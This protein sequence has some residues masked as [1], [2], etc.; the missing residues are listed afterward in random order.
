MSNLEARWAEKT[1]WAVFKRKS[2][3]RTQVSLVRLG[4]IQAYEMRIPGPRGGKGELKKVIHYGTGLS[5]KNVDVRLANA[6]LVDEVQRIDAEI[7]RLHEQR[8]ALLKDRLLEMQPLSWEELRDARDPWRRVNRAIE[9]FRKG[10]ATK[11]Y[12]DDV[13]RE[14]LGQGAEG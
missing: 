10:E 6:A 11:E 3:G 8:E 9:A 5:W 7:K 13:L 2:M 14:V 12:V 1:P 4:N